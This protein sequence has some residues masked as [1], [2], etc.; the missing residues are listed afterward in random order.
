MTLCKG[1][2]THQVD[3]C[4]NLWGGQQEINS[5]GAGREEGGG[6]VC[7]QF[8]GLCPS[9]IPTQGIGFGTE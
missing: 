3:V 9:L 8:L 2:G 7:L 4:S 5:W 6:E 1:A